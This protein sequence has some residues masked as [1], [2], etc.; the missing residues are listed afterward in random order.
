LK[1]TAERYLRYFGRAKDLP[2]VKELF[3]SK[4]KEEE[5]ENQMVVHY[6]KFVGQGPAYFGDL[7]ETDGTLLEFEQE[8]EEAGEP[9]SFSCQKAFNLARCSAFSDW[10]EAYLNIR[11]AIGIPVDE[12]PP[13]MPRW[14]VT[15]H[16]PTSHPP[17]PDQPSAKRKLRDAD[18]II[19]D[20]ED[21]K[22]AKTSTREAPTLTS[23]M[24]PSA[25]DAARA[26]AAFIP[27]LNSE[28]LAPP[29]LPSRDEMEDVLLGLRKKA[30]MSEYFGGGGE[31][32]ETK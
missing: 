29:Q 24:T 1:A 19:V 28:D 4:K 31:A 3:Q 7:D 25:D 8:A 9:S 18:S 12:D 20:A 14:N 26:A 16:P 21:L 17:A 6:R 27:F 13:R 2:G 10:E 15:R 23:S 5:E 30:L 32:V 22:R 11:T